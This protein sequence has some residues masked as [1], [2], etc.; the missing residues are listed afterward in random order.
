MRTSILRQSPNETLYGLDDAESVPGLHE[1]RRGAS[2]TPDATDAEF[3]PK[4]PASAIRCV[5]VAGFRGGA[6]L[7]HVRA[8]HLTV[9]DVEDTTMERYIL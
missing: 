1:S 3:F 2:A 6:D 5:N 4:S 7:G 9:R 8:L